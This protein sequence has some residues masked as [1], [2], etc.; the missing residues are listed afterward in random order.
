MSQ[1]VA[2]NR[3]TQTI[4]A[5]RPS[6]PQQGASAI[7]RTMRRSRRARRYSLSHLNETLSRLRKRATLRFSTVRSSLTTSAIRRSRSDEEAVSIAP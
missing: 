1:K 3:A 2:R 6:S 4:R 5:R 7:A